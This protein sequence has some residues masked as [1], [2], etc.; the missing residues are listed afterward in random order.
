MDHNIYWQGQML[1]QEALM[2]TILMQSFKFHA[3][4]RIVLFID[5]V[6]LLVKEKMVSIFYFLND[7]RLD[8]FLIQKRNSI[9]ILILQ[10]KL[11]IINNQMIIN[12]IRFVNY[13]KVFIIKQL[14][15]IKKIYYK[16]INKQVIKFYKPSKT[17]VLMMIIVEIA[18]NI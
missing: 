11:L 10:I 17:R 8:L 1:Q 12:N 14:I 2:Q 13:F 15:K 6:E 9:L 4:T 3:Q 18:F 5:Q 16:L 7:P